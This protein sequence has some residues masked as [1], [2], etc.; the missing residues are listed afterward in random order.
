[1]LGASALTTLGA[2]PPFLL[3]AQ[4]VLVR[5]DLD[6]GAAGLGVAVSA[7]FAVAA[8]VTIAAGGLFDRIEVAG[9][10]LAAGLLVGCGGLGIAGLAHDWTG[11]VL[12]MAVLGAANA[13]CQGASNRTIATL[14]PAGR[15]GLGFGLK[16]SAVPVAVML[17]GLAVPTMTAL[18]GWRSTFVVTGSVGLLVALVGVV[19]LTR[20]W[21]AAGRRDASAP[22]SSAPGAPARGDASARTVVDRAPW[23]PLLLCGLATTFASASANFLGSYLASWGH[24]VGLTVGQ[25]GL[26]MAA[27]SGASVVVRVLMGAR[28]DRRYG[29]NLTMVTTLIMVGALC[30]TMLALVP[31]IEVV[32]VFGFLA[33]GLGWSWPGLI[34]FAVAR[35][36][37]DAPTQASSVVQAGAFVG[38]ALGPVSFGVLVQVLGF[39][40]AWLAAAVS[41][42]ISG[43]L[44]LGA[45]R[46]FRRDLVSRPPAR[47]LGFGGGRGVPRFT[48][49]VPRAERRD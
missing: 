39:R 2:I 42:A 35:I 10:R 27:G 1:M 6:F 41:F 12:G 43:A 37:R 28:A 15:R 34:L 47:P 24:E 4:A 16:Q 9:A 23:G 3:G 31:R 18:L 40:G 22:T 13:T 20:S 14:L 46:G 11:L 36:G 45:R 32:V 30:L 44:V 7:F 48:T 21:W 8:L 17:G 29:G 19:G 5:G 26:L 25:A 38:G 49:P 33:F